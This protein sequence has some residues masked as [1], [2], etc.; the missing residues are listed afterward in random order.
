M[1]TRQGHEWGLIE[2]SRSRLTDVKLDRANKNI[3]RAVRRS[4]A[5]GAA[6][7]VGVSGAAAGAYAVGRKRGVEKSSG[8]SLAELGVVSKGMIP[9]QAWS[10]SLKDL[11]SGF[12]RGFKGQSMT[13]K[14]IRPGQAG[15]VPMVSKPA[16]FGNQAGKFVNR[17][18]TPLTALA[19]GG[20]AGMAAGGTAGYMAGRNGN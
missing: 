19:A 3:N 12:K 17:N 16:A 14:K 9:T 10:S 11:S 5:L 20:A 8:L 2:P 18:R 1:T 15:S 13:P 7:G 6:G 4:A